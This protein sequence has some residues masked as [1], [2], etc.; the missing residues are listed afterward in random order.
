MDSGAGKAEQVEHEQRVI[1]AVYARLDAELSEAV[2][3]HARAMA[4][5]ADGPAELSARDAEVGRLTERMRRLRSAEQSLC[6]GRVDYAGHGETGGT[7]LHIGRIGLRTEEGELLLVDWRAE[8]ARPFYSATMA[9]PLGLRRR[10]HLSLDGRR[11]AAVSDEILDGSAPTPDDVVGDGPLVEALGG[12]RTGRVYEAA[13]TLQAEQDEIVRSPH[14]GVMVVDGGPGTG[15]T[16]VAL[17][18]AAYVLYAFPAIAERGVLVFGPNRRFLAYISD[19]LPSLGENDVRLATLPD[20]I[21]VEAAHTDPDDLARTKGGT[22]CAGW[23]AQQRL[24][25][26]P[27]GAAPTSPYWTRPVP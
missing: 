5:Q 21:G 7:G 22:Q 19:V 9:S 27:A 4:A 11:V 25:R 13:A 1:D 18:R 14:R 17:H 23:L 10:R 6:F 3:A 26:S 8:A 20:L 12:A 24:P 15:K 16:I 2:V